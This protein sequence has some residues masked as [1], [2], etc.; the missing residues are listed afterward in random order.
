MEKN[1]S[2]Y[3]D[4]LGANCLESSIG[5][6]GH[7]G[8]WVGEKLTKQSGFVAK[9][10]K[11]FLGYTTENITSRLRKVILPLCLGLVRHLKFCICFWSL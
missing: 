10:T 8:I 5:K 2:K 1:N 7:R 3:Q 11:N 9:K 6:E 4:D